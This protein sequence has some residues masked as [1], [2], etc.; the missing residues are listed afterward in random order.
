M[1]ALC[2]PLLDL[3]RPYV[4][5]MLPQ[6]SSMSP[7]LAHVGP[8][9]ALCWPKLALFCSYVGPMFAYVTPI[10]PLCWPYVGVHWP[11]L[12]LCW[13]YVGL[14]YPY[15][16]PMLTLCSPMLALEMLSPIAVTETAE[17]TTGWGGGGEGVG[18][19]VGGA[20]LYNLRLPPKASGKD[21]GDPSVGRRPDL[22]ATAHAA[23]PWSV[24]GAGGYRIE[25]FCPMAIHAFGAHN[26]LCFW[27]T[28]LARR[29]A[30]TGIESPAPKTVENRCKRC[31]CQAPAKHSN[32]SRI[33]GQAK[34]N[35]CQKNSFTLPLEPIIYYAFGAQASQDRTHEQV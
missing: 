19:G 10:L 12:A 27:S 25:F 11:Y 24:P 17:V 9:L 6:V 16:A 22:R 34:Q 32:L 20:R 18:T 8:M 14:S 21:T 26:L 23:D 5:R 2:S 33:R 30:R 35:A 29:N 3:S 7:M 1:L 31:L 4:S 13:P 15:L 28:S